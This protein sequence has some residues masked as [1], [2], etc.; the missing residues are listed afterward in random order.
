MSAQLG[1][2]GMTAI[3]ADIMARFDAGERADD[4][5]VSLDLGRR[6]V[7]SVIQMYQEGRNDE[8][9]AAARRGSRN[10]LAAIRSAGA[11]HA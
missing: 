6:R 1:G 10:L 5:A 3:E 4:I 8:W 11:Q 7:M 9:Q 2:H